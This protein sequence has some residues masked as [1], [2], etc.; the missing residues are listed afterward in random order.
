VTQKEVDKLALQPNDILMNE[1]GDRD[2]L[3]RGWVWE[4]QIPLCIHQNHV[5]RVRLYDQ[6]FPAKLISYYANAFG[7]YF[8][9][10]QGKQ[11]TNLASISKSKISKLEIPIPPIDEAKEI[12]AKIQ[13]AFAWID[14]IAAEQTNATKL[15]GKLDQAVLAKAFRGDLVPQD[16]EDEPASVLLD[17]IRQER[18]A[19]PKAK[20]QPRHSSTKPQE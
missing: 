18:A 20:R 19:Q 3:G 10:E 13:S 17:R 11:T 14:R 12:L 1:G 2:K 9:M 16:P 4:G 6:D 5:F 15:L 7:Q 8:F